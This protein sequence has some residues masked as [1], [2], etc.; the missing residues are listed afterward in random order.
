MM[1]KISKHDS[2]ELDGFKV[3]FLGYKYPMSRKAGFRLTQKNGVPGSTTIMLTK[4][5]LPL[6]VGL[7]RGYVT[8]HTLN[9]SIAVIEYHE[10]EKPAI[11]KQKGGLFLRKLRRSTRN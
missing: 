8:V 4:Q 6:T 3:E 5:D 2:E 9:R 1:Q 10:P 11:D 7:T